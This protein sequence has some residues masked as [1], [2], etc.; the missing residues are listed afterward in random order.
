MTSSGLRIDDIADGLDVA[1]GD[2]RRALLL[3]HHALRA[4]ALH[5]D[6]DVLDVEH[7]VGHVL[8]HAGDRRELVQDAVDMDRGNRRALQRRQQNAP[9]RIAEG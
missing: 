4:I 9:Q 3:D 7:D 6:G 1:G 2:H 8:A 5:L